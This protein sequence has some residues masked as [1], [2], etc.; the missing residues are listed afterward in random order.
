[1]THQPTELSAVSALETDRLIVLGTLVLYLILLATLLYESHNQ[2]R[3]LEER[4]YLPY[5]LRGS[6]EPAPRRPSRSK[7]QSNL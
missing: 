1:M 2:S 7:R 5:E 6:C 3:S 4:G